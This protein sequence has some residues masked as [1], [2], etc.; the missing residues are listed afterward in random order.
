MKK[1]AKVILKKARKKVSK[2]LS[3][4]RLFFTFVIFSLIETVLLRNFT[5]RNTYDYKPFICDLALL[6]LIGSFGYFIKPKNQF[7]YYFIWLMVVTIMCI[8][9]SVYYVFYTSFASFSLIAELGLVGEVGDSLTEK[10]RLID[11]IYLLF[12]FFYI[13]MHTK[14]KR[15]SYYHFVSKVENGKKIC[16]LCA[17]NHIESGL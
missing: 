6:I 4:N 5:L 11:F 16:R 14:L 3:A 7:K 8:V 2:Y 1:K 13:G 17:K 12:P 9:N 10:F 15:G